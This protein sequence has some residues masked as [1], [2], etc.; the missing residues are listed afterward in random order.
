MDISLPLLLL[1][2]SERLS[3]FVL[4]QGVAGSQRDPPSLTRLKELS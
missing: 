3:D 4:P 1:I 2:F